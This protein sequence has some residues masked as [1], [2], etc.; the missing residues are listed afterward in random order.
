MSPDSLPKIFDRA[1]GKQFDYVFNCGG[2]TRYSQDDEIYKLRVVKLAESIGNEAAKRG[3]KSFVQLSSGHVYKGDSVPR[4]ETDKL[5][6]VVKL[7]QYQ[8]KAEEALLKIEGFVI[9]LLSCIILCMRE[10][11]SRTSQTKSD[12]FTTCN[13]VRKIRF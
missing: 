8:L 13:R 3:I 1:D 5:K 10:L 6:P 11:T 9:S 12:H 4:K 2:E 7:V